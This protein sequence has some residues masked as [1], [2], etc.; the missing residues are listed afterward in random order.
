MELLTFFRG[1][2]YTAVSAAFR[3]IEARRQQDQRL[4]R[5]LDKIEREISISQVFGF[6]KYIMSRL[7]TE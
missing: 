4:D 7:D 3:R 1:R 5:E 6:W 2:H